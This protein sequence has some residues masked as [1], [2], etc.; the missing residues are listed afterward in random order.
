MTTT[1][2]LPPGPRCPRCIERGWPAQFTDPPKCAWP[3]GRFE[4]NNW[5]CASMAILRNLAERGVYYRSEDQAAAMF[6]MPPREEGPAFILLSW[7][8]SR[9]RTEEAVLWMPEGNNG[10]EY[11]SLTLDDLE[12]FLVAAKNAP[13][14]ERLPRLYIVTASRATFAECLRL[15]QRDKGKRDGHHV[16]SARDLRGIRLEGED[17]IFEAADAE[18]LSDYPAIKEAIAWAKQ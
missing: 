5:N 12:A 2:T 4:T 18:T 13:A 9:G 15:I 14:P 11:R 17:A 7:Y 8:K 16:T 10:A 6:A 3:E 1:R